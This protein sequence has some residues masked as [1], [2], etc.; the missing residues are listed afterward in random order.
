MS[1]TYGVLAQVLWGRSFRIE[2]LLI[3][4]NN[5]LCSGCICLSVLDMRSTPFLGLNN[6]ANMKDVDYFQVMDGAQIFFVD[7]LIFLTNQRPLV[8]HMYLIHGPFVK[9]SLCMWQIEAWGPGKV[10]PK[11]W[12]R[13]Y[14]ILKHC[15][16]QFGKDHGS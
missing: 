13:M 9:W 10:I 12:K 4:L 7:P 1:Q 3:G 8:T 5:K 2:S 16:K 14:A 6:K 11:T 15:M